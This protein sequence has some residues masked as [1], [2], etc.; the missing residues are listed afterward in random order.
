MFIVFQVAAPEVSGFH[1]TVQSVPSLKTI[2][3]AGAV[4]VGSATAATKRAAK[5]KKDSI[6]FLGSKERE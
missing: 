2:P 3:G 1:W 6:G 4:G 5:A